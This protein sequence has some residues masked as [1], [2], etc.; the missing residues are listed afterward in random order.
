MKTFI[1]H[2]NLSQVYGYHA[3]MTLM[4]GGGINPLR[5]IG[6]ILLL[7]YIAQAM[8]SGHRPVGCADASDRPETEANVLFS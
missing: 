7:I 2:T 3:L 4:G 6:R 5:R 1:S 8:P